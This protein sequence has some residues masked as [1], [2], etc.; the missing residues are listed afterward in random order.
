MNGFQRIRVPLNNTDCVYG[1]S[2]KKGSIKHRVSSRIIHQISDAGG[3]IKDLTA[4]HAN[5]HSLT[6]DSK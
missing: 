2:A 1:R 4:A 5:A 3:L 6:T